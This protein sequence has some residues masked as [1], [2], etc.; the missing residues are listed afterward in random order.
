MTKRRFPT[1]RDDA[2]RPSPLAR[3]APLVPTTPRPPR[4]MS[5]RRAARIDRQR[6]RLLDWLAQVALNDEHYTPDPTAITPKPP[7]KLVPIERLDV[8]VRAATM[9]L[10][11]LGKPCPPPAP[12]RL[13]RTKNSNDSA[14]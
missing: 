5:A 12:L 9:V 8:R 4:P 1:A 7:P 14:A 10:Q 6:A 13:C 2:P 3:I 11:H